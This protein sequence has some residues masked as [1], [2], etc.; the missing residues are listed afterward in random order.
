MKTVLV[1]EV[2]AHF[3]RSLDECRQG[4]LV[5]MEDEHAVAMLL[6]VA[7]DED[8]ESLAL[9]NSARFQRLLEDAATGIRKTGGLTHEE[10]CKLLDLTP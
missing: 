5:V 1:Q 7:A 2:E 4:P 8:L 3:A 10:V 9:A 6:P